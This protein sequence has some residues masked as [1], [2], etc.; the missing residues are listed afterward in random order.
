MKHTADLWLYMMNIN[1]ITGNFTNSQCVCVCKRTER[2]PGLL[3]TPSSRE[4]D[5]IRAE[6]SEPAS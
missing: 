4:A 2:L 5:E 6:V 1:I 3:Q